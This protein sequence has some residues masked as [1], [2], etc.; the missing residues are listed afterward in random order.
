MGFK[1]DV[2]AAACGFLALIYL[3]NPSAGIVELIPDNVPIIGNLDEAAAT[4]LLLSSLRH[5]NVDVVSMLQRALGLIS[6]STGG[7]SRSHPAMD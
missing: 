6:S 3:L 4:A 2:F 7:R 1:E 5:F